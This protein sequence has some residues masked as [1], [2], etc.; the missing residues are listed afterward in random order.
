MN[1]TGALAKFALEVI[2]RDIPPEAYVDAKTAVLDALACA[3]AGSTAPGV[4]AIYEQMVEWAGKPEATL[5]VFGDRI[6]APNAAY[7]NGAL[8]HAL[9]FDDTHSPTCLHLTSVLVPAV[10]AASETRNASGKEALE[11]LI[12]GVE[13]ACRLG[14]A[15]HRRQV[16]LAS[17]PFLPASVIGGF[18]A[19]AAVARLWGLTLSETVNALGINYAEA[20]GNRQALFD[21]SLTKRLQPGLAARSALWSAALARRGVTGPQDAIEGVAGL[22]PTYFGCDAPDP[23]EVLQSQDFW[24]ISRLLIKDYPSCGQAHPLTH[25]GIELAKSGEIDPSQVESI[26]IYLREGKNNVVGMP[27]EIGDNPQVDVQFSAAYGAACGLL[28]GR[29]GLEEIQ[30]EQI[31]SDTRVAD[32]A[33]NAKIRTHLPESE[34][35][36]EWRKGDHILWVKMRD[37]RVIHAVSSARPAHRDFDAVEKKF[38]SCASFSG[39]SQNETDHLIELVA[40]MDKSPG[41]RTMLDGTVRQ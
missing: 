25:A 30:D 3:I 24:D 14:R 22:F 11:A 18:G 26:E 29:F 33:R 16:N 36:T 7:L 41:I 39:L 23:A 5:L 31:R 19:V 28:R 6:V 21:K 4:A 2:D 1:V 34:R 37:G 40:T 15:L 35:P 32:L 27:F 38:R 9:D 20:S 13:V 12:V 10:F 8:V 17:G